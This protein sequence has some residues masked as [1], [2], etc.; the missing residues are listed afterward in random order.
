MQL[1]LHMRIFIVLISVQLFSL[2][3]SAQSFNVETND[4]DNFWK[5]YDSIKKLSSVNKPKVFK[6]L[7]LDKASKSFQIL[8]DLSEDLRNA[9][10][11]I[12]SIEKYPAFWESLRAPSEQ[13]KQDI[14][15]NLESSYNL[16]REQYPPFKSANTLI[17]FGARIIGGSSFDDENLIV[18]SA[19]LNIPEKELNM[20]E[21]KDSSDISENTSMHH[22]IIH[23]SIHFNQKKEAETLLGHALLEGSAD[24][25]ATYFTGEEIKTANFLFGE[26]FESGL[27]NEFKNKM[28]SSDVSDWL[29]GNSYREDR[30]GDLGYY[31]GYMITKSYFENSTNKAEAIKEI[32][33]MTDFYSF[34]KDSH[35][36]D[37]FN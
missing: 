12:E 5:A 4:I 16:I 21:L 33:E 10:N 27:W 25:L 28:T 17:F 11:Y 31:L 34:L 24:F 23:E 15:L 13:L 32:I 26:Q 36:E 18:L 8:L 2:T 7:Y 3:L 20:D 22:T 14:Y 29:Y 37:K 35:Y 1:F 6:Q 19:E 30:P 9:N